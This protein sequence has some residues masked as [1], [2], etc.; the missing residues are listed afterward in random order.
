MTPNLMF[1][2]PEFQLLMTVTLVSGQ[3]LFLSFQ[4]QYFHLSLAPNFLC[5]FLA[6]FLLCVHSLSLHYVNTPENR[7]LEIYLHR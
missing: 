1:S 7:T 3:K 6:I 5:S 2:A 4:G